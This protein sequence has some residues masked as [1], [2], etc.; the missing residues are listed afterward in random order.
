MK[1]TYADQA[2]LSALEVVLTHEHKRVDWIATED[3]ESLFCL[4]SLAENCSRSQSTA[5]DGINRRQL[6]VCVFSQRIAPWTAG[7]T[8]NWMG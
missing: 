5:K 2:L 3:V 6:E 4:R 7:I 8:M 1:S